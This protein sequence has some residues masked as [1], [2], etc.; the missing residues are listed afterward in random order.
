M[1]EVSTSKPVFEND[2]LP[3]EQQSFIGP[4]SLQE[5]R[6]YFTQ[7]LSDDPGAYVCLYGSSMYKPFSKRSDVDMFVATD[8][9]ELTQQD[10]VALASF[11]KDFHI[12]HGRKVDEEV[13]YENKIVY[14]PAERT[15]SI[16]LEMFAG[17][18][19]RPIQKTIEYLSGQEIKLRLFLNAMTTPHLAIADD[20]SIYLAEREAAERSVTTLGLAM[21]NGQEYSIDDIY[22]AL[23]LGPNNEFGEDH[24]GYKINYPRVGAHLVDIL[25]RVLPRLNTQIA[26][27]TVN[28]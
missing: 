3:E 12:R 17:G 25:N 16:N 21:Q 15:A 5:L 18:K 9:I 13:P 6:E 7:Y 1:T 20:P 22:S 28:K 19:V 2:C 26:L 8:G 4:E 10:T 23:T 27:E 24:L 14:K 11:I